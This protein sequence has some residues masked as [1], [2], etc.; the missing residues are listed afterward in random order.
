MH[1]SEIVRIGREHGVELNSHVVMRWMRGKGTG[2]V[3]LVKSMLNGLR[4]EEKCES[5]KEDGWGVMGGKLQVIKDGVL[6]EGV[7]EM[8]V[9]IEGEVYELNGRKI[10]KRI[11]TK[12][13]V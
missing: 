13:N 9:E 10:G 8:R 2:A 3:E 6:Y 7:L 1:H 11:K 12:S 4:L 5:D